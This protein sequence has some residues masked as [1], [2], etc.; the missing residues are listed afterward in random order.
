[1]PKSKLIHHNVYKFNPDA[2]NQDEGWIT[3]T[4]IRI[5]YELLNKPGS[6]FADQ[7]WRKGYV[8]SLGYRFTL[9]DTKHVLI[10][11]TNEYGNEWNEHFIPNTDVELVREYV[12]KYCGDD[13]AFIILDDSV[14]I[15]T[16]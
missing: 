7:F 13:C 3:G 16:T 6:S 5:E 15:H 8:D 10:T 12:N 4:G 9:D 2:P 11:F 1:M 14:K